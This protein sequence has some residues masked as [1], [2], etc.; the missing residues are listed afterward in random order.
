MSLFLSAP[1]SSALR[2]CTPALRRATGGLAAA[3]CQAV[4]SRTFID[5]KRLLGESGPEPPSAGQLLAEYRSMTAEDAARCRSPPRRCSMLAR[6]F[7]DDSLYNPHYGYF[8]K[9]ATIFTVEDDEGFAFNSCRDTLEFMNRIGARYA[10]IEGD[11][12]DPWYGYAIAKYIATEYKLNHFPQEDLVIYEIGAGNGTLMLNVLDYLRDNEPAV[13]KRTQ[14]RI[15]E[16]SPKLA[17]RQTQR[18]EVRDVRDA[19]HGRITIVNR[20]IFDWDQ[21]VT[22]S[23]FF[24]AME[25]IDNFAHDVIR[26]NVKTGEP[27]Q[28]F[29]LAP[30][31]TEPEF[32]P[33]KALLLLEKLRDYF[34]RHRLVLSDFYTLPDAVP[35]V[36][37]PVVQTR[38]QR[39]MVPCSTYLVQPGWFDIFYPT[40]F[41]LL[42]DVYRLVCRSSRPANTTRIMGEREFLE[43]F[44]DVERTRT[45]S[46]ENPM[47][48]YYE[49][50][51][52]LLS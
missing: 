3:P 24:I 26:Y 28:W 9:Q 31:L 32:L 21:P 37:A 27:M 20:S 19:H 40:N 15:I 44:A 47:L 30:N 4:P 25:V 12:N 34:P 50:N 46:G 36:D 33:T 52:F 49:N 22:E 51:K 17:E 41:E 43:R 48:D 16:I 23:C 7:V 39:T 29:P 8:S 45:I 14:Y 13:Y 1:L 38:Y 10:E 2:R 6:D 11:L 35:G 5:V 42:R 18:H